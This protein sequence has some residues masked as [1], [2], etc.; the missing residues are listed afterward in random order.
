MFTSA[1]STAKRGALLIALLS[2]SSAW[3]SA[4][5]AVMPGSSLTYKMVHKL[6]EVEGVSKSVEG[7]AVVAEDG[8]VVVQA[9]VKVES[10]D[11]N[12]GN[13]DAHMKE[14]TEA[15]KF[16]YVE[17]KAASVPGA[18]PKGATQVN[19]P[20]KGKVTFH[21]IEQPFSTTVTV[22]FKDATHATVSG[23]FPVS[24]E[25]HKIERPSLLTVKVS[26]ELKIDIKLV[27]E[28]E[29]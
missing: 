26:D 15:S 17:I 3:A 4:K 7:K 9:R 20:L 2:L 1:I 23:G 10:F 12:N 13:R 18:V 24:L 29:K 5:Y 6:H 16:P 14:V 19:V 22:V 21:G 28:A 11:S 27:L 8:H 25:A